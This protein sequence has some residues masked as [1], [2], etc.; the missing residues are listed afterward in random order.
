MTSA[1]TASS[2]PSPAAPGPEDALLSAISAVFGSEPRKKN[3]EIRKLEAELLAV[4]KLK[5]LG[6]SI[7][8][9]ANVGANKTPSLVLN[10]GLKVDVKTRNFGSPTGLEDFSIKKNGARISDVVLCHDPLAGA[11]YVFLRGEVSQL[12]LDGEFYYAPD[13]FYFYPW[14]SK[15]EAEFYAGKTRKGRARSWGRLFSNKDRFLDWSDAVLNAGI[16]NFR[17]AWDKLKSA[18]AAK[19]AKKEKKE[20]DVSDILMS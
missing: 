20:L 18:E 9:L 15:E 7:E 16:G 13:C 14:K 8:S 2:A 1:K 5:S 12:W 17:E 10:G 6:Y 11:F 19:P 4:K 3:I